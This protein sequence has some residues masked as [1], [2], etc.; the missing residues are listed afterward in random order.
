ASGGVPLSSVEA[1]DPASGT[2]SAKAAM[3]TPRYEV[4]AGVINGI[5]YAVGGHNASTALN[6]VEAYDPTTNTWSTKA[7]MP[8]ARSAA[9]A[10]VNGI[11]CDRRLRTVLP[12]VCGGRGIRP[13]YRYMDHRATDADTPL[14][15]RRRCRQWQ[16]LCG[17]RCNR[18]RI[19]SC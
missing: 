17:W 15:A 12:T 19:F 6:T 13:E 1:F 8:T 18:R 10:V 16:H 9:V 2:W 11:L 4:G 7:S 5:L 14:F 3:P